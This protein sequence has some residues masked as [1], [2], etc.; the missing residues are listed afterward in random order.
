M[1]RSLSDLQKE[2]DE[3]DEATL[4]QRI[5]DLREERKLAKD[6]SSQH[7]AKKERKKESTKSQLLKILANM[8]EEQRVEFMK[9]L[10]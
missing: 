8:T 1:V 6:H 9:G 4:K 5:R 2:F 10:S 3:L 7:V